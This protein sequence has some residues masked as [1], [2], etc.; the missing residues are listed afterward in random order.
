[1]RNEKLLKNLIN[2]E[3]QEFFENEFR[4]SNYMTY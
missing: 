2:E 4:N 1:M 3:Q